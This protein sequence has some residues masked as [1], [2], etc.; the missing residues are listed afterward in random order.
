V[1]GELF[2]VGDAAIPIGASLR[3]NRI[4]R[5]ARELVLRLAL[6]IDG[7]RNARGELLTPEG[8]LRPKLRALPDTQLALIEAVFERVRQQ[9]APASPGRLD[10]IFLWPG[11][12][13]ANQFRSRY[14]PT[15]VVHRCALVAGE[16]RERDAA[17]VAAGVDVSAV[18]DNEARRVAERAAIYWRNPGQPDWPEVLAHG[19]VVVSENLG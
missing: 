19:I 17:L 13:L 16:V 2:H 15:G 12:E 3:P 5:E 11:L 6:A 1:V 14:R 9:V 7:D 18:L 4:G 8:W 10:A